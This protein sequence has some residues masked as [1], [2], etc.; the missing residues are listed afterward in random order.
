MKYFCNPLNVN[1]RYQFNKDQRNGGAIK[2][3]REAADPSMILFKGRYYIFASMTLG[4]WVS[5]DLVRWENHR[6]PD[7]LPLYDYAPDVRVLGDWVYFCAS[8]RGQ[9]C[10]RYRTKDIL[11]GPYEKTKGTFDYWDPNLFLDDDG[12]VYFYWGCTNTDPIWGVELDPE[13]MKPLGEKTA[14]IEKG[15]V[16]GIGIGESQ[17]EQVAYDKA[18]LNARTDIGRELESKLQN[19]TRAYAEEVGSELTQH[20]EEVK[21]NVVSTTI[22]GATIIKIKTEAKENGVKVYAIMAMDPKLV[23]EA[24]EAELAAKQADVARFRASK[25]YGDANKE[26]EAYEAAKAA[27]AQ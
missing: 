23:R 26:F 13:T 1:Y 8:R 5:D 21:K 9:K 20:F 10:D 14:L 2:I 22:R 27:A 15:V 17:D 24:F 11:A 4:V 6:L 19:L 3:C 7:A 16:A 25:A 12:R 18:D